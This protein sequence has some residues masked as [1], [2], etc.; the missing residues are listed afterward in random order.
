[1]PCSQALGLGKPAQLTPLPEGGTERRGVSQPPS[2]P[3]SCPGPGWRPPCQ[4]CRVAGPALPAPQFV[5]Q[6]LPLL[7]ARHLLVACALCIGKSFIFL[8]LRRRVLSLNFYVCN[9]S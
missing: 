9:P 6:L 1:M 4:G 5:L 7:R 8:S 2:R 3:R